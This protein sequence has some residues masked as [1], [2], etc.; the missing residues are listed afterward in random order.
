MNRIIDSSIVKKVSIIFVIAVVLISGCL[1]FAFADDSTGTF[2]EMSID[3]FNLSLRSNICIKFAVNTGGR[4]GVKLLVFTSVQDSYTYG[5]HNTELFS[6]GTQTIGETKYQIFDLENVLAKQ[7][8]D[9]FY[10]VAYSSSDDVY[11]APVKYSVLDYAYNVLGKTNAANAAYNPDTAALKILV[12]DLL[13][14][15]GSSQV[16]FDYNTDRLASDEYY[17]VTVEGGLLEDGFNSGLYQAGKSAVL[18]APLK[19][20]EGLSFAGWEDSQG[21]IVGYSPE[22][23]LTV[24]ISNETYTAVYGEFADAF[25]FEEL[26]DGTYAVAGYNGTSGSIVIPDTYES[27]AVTSIKSSAFKGNTS[28]VYVR[29]PSSVT[30]IGNSAFADCSLLATVDVGDGVEVIGAKAFANTAL[31]EIV[32]PDSLQSIGQSTFAG[33]PIQSMTLPFIGGSRITSNAFIGY[34][35]GA[36]SYSGNAVKVPET[37]T[38]V[39]VSGAAGNVPAYAF[40]GLS[41]LTSVVLQSGITTVGNSAFSDCISLEEVYIAATVTDIPANAN[42][43]NSPFY[44][45]NSNIMLVL[46][47]AYADGFGE[48]WKSINESAEALVVYGRSY[49]DYTM[50]K[51]GYRSLDKNVATLDS[52]TVN[53]V[54]IDSFASDKLDYT[55]DVDIND[56]Y[57]EISALQTS[58]LSEIKIT[59]PTTENSGISGIVVTSADG[60]VTKTY[61]VQVNFIGTFNDVSAEVVGKDGTT[62]TVTFV[63]DDGD[64]TTASFTTEMMDKY[65][66]L[67]FTY[68]ILT[69]QLA[70]VKISYDALTG[71]YAYVMDDGRY[72]YTVN[73]TNV[74]FWKDILDNYDTEVVSHTYSHAF[75]GNNDDGGVQKYV[76]SSGNLLTSGNLPIG[77]ATAEIY[78]SIQLIEELLGIRAVTHVVPGIGVSTTDKVVDGV[79]YET[80]YTYYEQLLREAIESGDILALAGNTMGSAVSSTNRYVTK[81]TIKALGVNGV[82]RLLLRPTDDMELWTRFID[83][84]A[85]NNGWATYCIHKITEA[86]TSGHYILEKDAE[87]MFAYAVSKNIWIANYTEAFFY[88]TEWSSAK[89]SSVYD[90][91]SIKVT[92]T[93]D[94]D[95]SMYNEELTVKVAVP[96]SW[97]AA[98]ANGETLE[99]YTAE[100][101]SFYVLINIV[102]D[103]GEVSISKKI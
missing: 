30:N 81:D 46:E 94:E 72:T 95:N 80:Y 10:V 32:L 40:Y 62:G 47:A 4:S 97:A 96:A 88:Y 99:V 21:N 93:D 87:N 41:N 84:A 101:G 83:N 49:E 82:A 43:F 13:T 50:N 14:Y 6:V 45:T 85:A 15:G 34:L 33:T 20:G 78:A 3:H 90:N 100:D 61:T 53:G 92:L 59:K 31:T 71:R 89:V 44:N 54:A 91:G 42:V 27:K 7:M 19:N 39:T 69:N 74:D 63:V 36:L 8:T 16:Y 51:D 26:S 22:L 65:D 23:E 24:G 18:S 2:T 1:V 9:T 70:T 60:T 37:L 103:S 77:S 66:K 17:L 55:V 52:I 5:T 64:Q 57:P 28:I 79:N 76:D 86:A 29:I 56:G 12:T 48:Y 73:Q 35:F 75:W 38:S 58:A 102:P 68:A 67:K 11:S 98:E 25:V